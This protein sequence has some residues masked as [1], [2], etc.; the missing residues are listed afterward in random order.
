MR[1]NLTKTL[2]KEWWQ[3]GREGC[4]EDQ[5][6]ACALMPVHPAPQYV[7]PAP[8]LHLSHSSLQLGAQRGQRELLTRRADFLDVEVVVLRGQCQPSVYAG[9]AVAPV[10]VC[11][12]A[13]LLNLPVK[14]V[15]LK[16]YV[17]QQETL[18]LSL[19]PHLQFTTKMPGVMNFARANTDAQR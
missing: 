5:L 12:G 8:G 11:G 14:C 18:C 19:P 10:L 17:R 15:G 9:C 6:S 13:Q 2:K 3:I 7:E 16:Y 4:K 1:V